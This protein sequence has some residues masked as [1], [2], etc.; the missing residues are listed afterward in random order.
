M[1]VALIAA[2][3]TNGPR[4][5][6]MDWVYAAI[7]P[8]MVVQDG[9]SVNVFKQWWE[10]A[11]DCLGMRYEFKR[12]TW[13]V[14]RTKDDGTFKMGPFE[15]LVGFTF[16]RP[17]GG[18]TIVLSQMYWMEPRVVRHESIHAI[19]GKPHGQLPEAV[20]ARCSLGEGP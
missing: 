7:R 18:V 12:V 1:A 17:R 8:P 11:E 15:G 3:G 2:C 6:D 14:I 10:E 4:M 5:Q 19:T 9:T 13:M 20:F 16:A